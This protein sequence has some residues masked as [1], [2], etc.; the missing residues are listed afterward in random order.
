[1]AGAVV[2]VSYYPSDSVAVEK[3]DALWLAVLAVI[4]AT[5]ACAAR[6]WQQAETPVVNAT[7]P[8]ATSAQ[9][10]RGQLVE[11]GDVGTQR[12]S[13]VVGWLDDAGCI[14]HFA[15]GKPQV[16]DQ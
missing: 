16:G 12:D 1:M 14:L 3:G 10:D 2:Y 9:S 4:I 13:L 7:D 6:S 5:I 8:D 15:A 11:D